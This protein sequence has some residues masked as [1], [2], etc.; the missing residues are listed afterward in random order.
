MTDYRELLKRYMRY[1]V[2]EE[3]IS[4]VEYLSDFGEGPLSAEDVAELRR[5]DAELFTKPTCFPHIKMTFEQR[6]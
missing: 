6:L 3:G 2:Q 4:Y 5:I 1:V